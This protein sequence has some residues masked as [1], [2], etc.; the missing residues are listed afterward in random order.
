MF[1]FAPPTKQ[2]YPN[3]STKCSKPTQHPPEGRIKRHFFP[4]SPDTQHPTYNFTTAQRGITSGG[5]ISLSNECMM[6]CNVFINLQHP[7]GN[8]FAFVPEYNHVTTP[9]ISTTVH[10]QYMVTI[11]DNGKHAAASYRNTVQRLSLT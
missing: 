2:F 9:H 6:T 5:I 1:G 7:M 4:P 10:Y 11:F 8:K 3:Q